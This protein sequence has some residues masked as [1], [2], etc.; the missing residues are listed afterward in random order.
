MADIRYVGAYV[1]TG[2]YAVIT[3]IFLILLNKL[4]K[5]LLSKGYEEDPFALLAYNDGQPIKY[6]AFT[7]VLVICGAVL[8]YLLSRC[9]RFG[10][11]VE[12][13]EFILLVLLFLMVIIS[14]VLIIKFICIPIF[15]AILAV[16][17]LGV[18]G[19]CAFRG[20]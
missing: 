14:I 13:W 19:V 17:F 10:R 15:Q 20:R 18:L 11:D 4:N 2:I 9:I 8:L 1:L 7:L 3:T 6:F 12:P 16:C 5:V